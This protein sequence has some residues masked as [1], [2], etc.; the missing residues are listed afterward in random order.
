MLTYSVIP[1]REGMLYLFSIPEDWEW[2]DVHS[3]DLC[4]VCAARDHTGPLLLSVSL[5]NLSIQKAAHLL[6]KESLFAFLFLKQIYMFF[7]M[8]TRLSQLSPE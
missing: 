5:Q 1:S 3:G 6:Y 2:M 4:A 7:I 8:H